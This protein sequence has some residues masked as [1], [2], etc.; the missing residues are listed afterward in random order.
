MSKVYESLMHEMQ[1]RLHRVRAPQSNVVRIKQDDARACTEELDQLQN[2]FCEHIVRLKNAIAEGEGVAS[3]EISDAEAI[4]RTLQ[5]HLKTLEG[6]LV[7]SDERFRLQ[8]EEYR[9]LQEQLV[10]KTQA[11]EGETC[12]KQQLLAA[13]EAQENTLANLRGDMDGQLA[14]AREYNQELEKKEKLLQTRETEIIEL[15]KR[16][17][18]LTRGIKDMSSVFTRIDALGVQSDDFLSVISH[19]D[20]TA[21]QSSDFNSRGE[22]LRPAALTSTEDAMPLKFFHDLTDP[23]VE[24]VGPI[25]KVIVRDQVQALGASLEAFPRERA[26][27]LVDLLADEILDLRGKARF[28]ERFARYAPVINETAG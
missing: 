15:K 18:L 22:V 3:R 8:Q 23:L 25:A 4:I 24:T 11:L 9:A 17:E 7:A 12:S 14:H 1:Q 27:E 5:E 21:I 19:A 13:L 6:E 28:R 26:G 20:Q 16:L 2:T 10:A